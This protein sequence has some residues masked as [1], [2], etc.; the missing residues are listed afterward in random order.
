V[1]EQPTRNAMGKLDCKLQHMCSPDCV[2]SREQ[3]PVAI[4]V[5]WSEC[6][7]LRLRRIN[8]Y[9]AINFIGWW[10]MLN[11]YKFPNRKYELIRS[12][13]LCILLDSLRKITRN[14]S[15]Y[16]VPQSKFKASPPEYRATELP[17]RPGPRH[18]SGGWSPASHRG[19]PSSI[20]VQVMWDL[21]WTKW[22]WGRF[23]PSISVSPANSHSI[24]C[25]TLISWYNR[26]RGLRTKWTQSKPWG[27]R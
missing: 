5:Q 7:I 22:R 19:G 24:D 23:S 25:S 17:L 26:P 20:P 8:V 4:Y 27:T 21:W 10:W 2:W 14:L 18:S 11:R 13:R 9:I 6:I 3:S 1:E 16:P 15:G 12:Y